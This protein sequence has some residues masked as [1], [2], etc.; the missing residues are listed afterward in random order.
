MAKKKKIVEKVYSGSSVKPVISELVKQDG[1]LTS[2]NIKKKW[3]QIEGDEASKKITESIN[4]SIKSQAARQARL[5]NSARLYQNQDII[6]LVVGQHDKLNNSSLSSDKISYNLIASAV[7]TIYNKVVKNKT[8]VL[9]LTSGAT[10]DIKERGQKLS[11]YTEGV[12]DK[13]SLYRE[14]SKAI[15]DSLVFGDGFIKFFIENDFISCE[16]IM[17]K[18]IVVDENEG[19][20]GKPKTLHQLKMVDKESLISLFPEFAGK[21]AHAG[22]EIEGY[23]SLYSEESMIMVRESWKLPSCLGAKDGKRIISIDNCVLHSENY[24]KHYFPFVHYQWKERLMGYYG[25]GIPEELSGLQNEINVLLERIKDAHDLAALPRVWVRK[26]EVGSI[27]A[28]LTNDVGMICGYE[29]EK[30]IIEAPAW[31][32]PP[33][34]YSH[35]ERLWQRGFEVVGISQLSAT[36]K[37]PSGLNSAVAL[38][39]YQDIESE[40]LSDF[41]MKYEEGILEGAKIIIDLSRDL[42]KEKANIKISVKGK[43]FLESIDW[44]EAD[45]D[46]DQFIMKRYPINAL[47]SHP[48]GRLDKVVELVQAGF[49]PKE[50][51]LSLLDYPDLESAM[52][53]DT[54]SYKIILKILQKMIK[55]GKYIAPEPFLNLQLTLETSQ[56]F[57]YSSKMDDVKEDKLEL[58]RRFMEDV[59]T[60][61]HQQM[62]AIN[63]SNQPIGNPMSAP[64]SELLPYK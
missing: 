27:A 38:R 32:L 13:I 59:V 64:K 28:Q 8:K 24:D 20:Y 62:S 35:L 49:I 57:Y 60:L 58:I 26:E 21:I 53:L 6:D 9:F 30:P 25:M 41:I 10:E 1:R 31:V 17:P 50:Q 15:L 61:Q 51:A 14:F 43:K 63:N 45:L 7:D 40:R 44:K 52:D 33:E 37:K 55:D 48:A 46:E 12:F 42:Y 3:Y 23:S 56:S 54:S 2:S 39:T 47:P 16:R 4:L 34:V 11:K 22:S 19:V 36:S 18:E 5:L 29:K